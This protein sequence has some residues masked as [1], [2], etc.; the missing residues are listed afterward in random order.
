M[1]PELMTKMWIAKMMNV[2][3]WAF[4]NAGLVGMRLLDAATSHGFATAMVS[5]ICLGLVTRECTLY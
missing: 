2:L 4:K 5:P 3:Q 1:V